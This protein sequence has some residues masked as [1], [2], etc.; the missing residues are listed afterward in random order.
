MQS[1]FVQDE[2]PGYELFT[3]DKL[4]IHSQ[5]VQDET[6]E[7]GLFEDEVQMASQLV[8]DEALKHWLLENKV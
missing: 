5:F 7:H 6:L 8:Q 3:P 2:A 4:R 1:R